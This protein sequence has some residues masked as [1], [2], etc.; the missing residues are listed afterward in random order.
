MPELGELVRE[1]KAE[2]G[3]LSP[4]KSEASGSDLNSPTTVSSGINDDE[5]LGTQ[6]EKLLEGLG[7]DDDGDDKIPTP[8]E[9]IRMSR[10]RKEGASD[11]RAQRRRRRQLAMSASEASLEER[12][13]VRESAEIE[14]VGTGKGDAIPEEE[15][16]EEEGGE[17]PRPV[18]T[19]DAEGEGGEV[20]VTPPSPDRKGGGAG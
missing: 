14:S 19:K 9:S 20:V 2:N 7:G 15:D 16:E 13:H 5:D 12:G 10:R 1:E 6:A 18:K 17:T 8:R 4:V 11:E 3:L